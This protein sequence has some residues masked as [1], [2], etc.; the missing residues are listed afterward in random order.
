MTVTNVLIVED[1]PDLA[2]LLERT[3]KKEGYKTLVRHSGKRIGDALSEI[4][5]DLVLL[6]LMLPDIDGYSLCR[7]IKD[8]NPTTKPK[9]IMLTAKTEEEDVLEGFKAGADDF[10]IKPFQLHEVIARSKA[11]LRRH[12][13]HD[14]NSKKRYVRRGPI[15]IDDVKHEVMIDGSPLPLTISEYKILH[16]LAAQPDRVFS[17]EQLGNCISDSLGSSD[18][19]GGSRNIDVHIRALRKKLGPQSERICTLRGVGYYF[20]QVKEGNA[21]SLPQSSRP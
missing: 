3:L 17:R 16:Q 9:V 5:P 8:S 10:I 15:C 12:R 2:F 13:K 20:Q 19:A 4:E 18:Q 14:R 7:I 1:D 11:V 6:D 21:P